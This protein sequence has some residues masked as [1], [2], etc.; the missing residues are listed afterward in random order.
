MSD[1]TANVVVSMPSQLFT[2]A[3]SFKAVANGKIYIG[4][5]DTDPVNPENQIQ[6]YVEN[7][8]GSHVPVSQ[9]IIINAAGYPVYNGQIAKFVTEQGHSMAVYD[10]YGA[11]Q[12]YFPNVLKYD[13][14]QLEKRLSL[15]TGA[16]L[17]GT[18][19]G[20]SIQS[21]IDCINESIEI[22]NNDEL[23]NLSLGVASS[24]KTSVQIIDEIK[25][26]SISYDAFGN[27]VFYNGRNLFCFRRSPEHVDTYTGMHSVC[28]AEIL[29]NGAC[30]IIWEYTDN[31]GN[32]P[33]D[34]TL[35]VSNPGN[36][37]IISFQIHNVSSDTYTSGI[38]GYPDLS[39]T[40]KF[41]SSSE[42]TTDHNVF[43]WGNVLQTPSGNF[44]TSRYKIDGTGVEII[45]SSDTNLNENTTWSIVS[46]LSVGSFPTRTS[47][48]ECSLSYYR[49]QLVA[50]V[51]TQSGSSLG[52]FGYA[53][54][55][56][57]TGASGWQ[58]FTTSVAFA[59][60]R[61]EAYPDYDSPLV[62]T[63][64]TA[65]TVTP[66]YRSNVSVSLTFDLST[67]STAQVVYQ[68]DYLNVYASSKKVGEGIY[69]VIS[70]DEIP[71]VLNKTKIQRFY[72]Y[73][74]QAG[75]P[76][77]FLK[78]KSDWE[79]SLI[80]GYP[81]YGNLALVNT[82]QSSSN[83]YFSFNERVGGINRIMLLI[84][85]QTSPE[86]LTPVI[87]KDDDSIYAYCYNVIVTGSNKPQIIEIIPVSS[88]LDFNY[89][90]RLRLSLGRPLQLGCSS[91]VP[92]VRS[93]I[94]SKLPFNMYNV[95][96][97]TT[98]P[99]VIIAFGKL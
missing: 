7:E 55:S 30:K 74:S 8:D 89:F 90:G 67:F 47:V 78:Y 75:R 81:C 72:F 56:D 9:P 1:I 99:Y 86:T 14:D 41:L 62:I 11:Q 51:R 32:A 23:P 28:I 12:F 83:L 77:T 21:E 16:S 10:A 43:L 25:D 39:N 60:P 85:P 44:I 65:R 45:S 82:T 64:T 36:T 52:G 3:R 70:F 61:T 18:Y 34:P 94:S 27:S 95:V 92:G 24:I 96:G 19:S 91:S 17:I 20:A 79:Q 42:L 5:I 22:I 37:L 93:P 15:N 71:D 98:S 66:M 50:I 59:G 80:N 35:S 13:P 54:T 57:L 68:G 6:V 73:T 48:N 97:N 46:T 87:Y 2:M 76:K 33:K 53:K 88:P 29:N 4:K 58:Y 40:G 26:P 31:T 63:G 84:G 38:I 49:N 69:E